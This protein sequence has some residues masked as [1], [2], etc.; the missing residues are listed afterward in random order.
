M[1]AAVI[2]Y[3]CSNQLQCSMITYRRIPLTTAITYSRLFIVAITYYSDITYGSSSYVLTAVIT[4]S[5][6]ITY[7]SNITYCKYTIEHNLRNTF[8]C[9]KHTIRI[10]NVTIM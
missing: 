10:Y 7:S 6:D 5:C 8:G 9:T 1:L 3:S 4:Y 2:A